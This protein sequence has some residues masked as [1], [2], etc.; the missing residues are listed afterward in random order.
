MNIFI[1]STNSYDPF[2]ETWVDEGLAGLAR[3]V[4]GYGHRESHVSAFAQSPGTSLTF[5]QDDL[6]NY[7]ATYLFMLF[8][9]E[10]YGGSTTTTRKIVANTGIGIAGMN[11]ALSQSGQSVAVQRYFQELGDCQLSE[12]SI[13]LRRNLCVHRQFLG[14]CPAPPEIF[15]P[16]TLR[17]LIPT[18]GNG[19]VDRYAAN[20]IRFTGLSGT[21]DTFILVPYSLSRTAASQSY[22]AT[23]SE[24]GSLI[25]E[26]N[27]HKRH[28]GDGRDSTGIS[29]PTPIVITPL[30]ESNTISTGRGVSSSGGGRRRR[31]VLHRHGG[32]RFTPGAGGGH[33]PGIPRPLSYDE[34][35]R[36]GPGFFRTMPGALAA[37]GVHLPA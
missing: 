29:N 6:E 3:F 22:S 24:C 23:P 12:Q 30:S 18:S 5:W 20:Y 14:H 4:C 19:D 36:S 1:S 31:R 7:G 25:L 11:S 17:A 35:S 15:N 16:P 21:Y 2:E 28:V 37:A 26:I 10:H 27:R 32:V 9:A 33:P 34:S 13:D 8:L